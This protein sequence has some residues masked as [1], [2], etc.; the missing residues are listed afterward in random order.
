MLVIVG[1][2]VLTGVWWIGG[3]VFGQ[4]LFLCP[5]DRDVV[6]GGAGRGRKWSERARKVRAALRGLIKLRKRDINSFRRCRPRYAQWMVA[7]LQIRQSPGSLRGLHDVAA[8][9]SR[10]PNQGQREVECIIQEGTNGISLFQIA[11]INKPPASVGKVQES[12]YRAVFDDDGFYILN[13]RT[14]QMMT[15]NREKGVFVLDA[16][17]LQDAGGDVIVGTPTEPENQLGF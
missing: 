17:L 10:I 9:G 3:L 15:V 7:W 13:K 16:R 8:N 11:G 6:M 12:G 5:M 14:G 4:D 1:H 2:A